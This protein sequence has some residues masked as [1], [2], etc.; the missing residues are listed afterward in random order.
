MKIRAFSVA[1]VAAFAMSATS[2]TFAGEPVLQPA[3][4]PAPRKQ[5]LLEDLAAGMRD[6]LRTVVPEIALPQ[7]DLKLPTLDSRGR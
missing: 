1:A 3:E 4:S 5:T 6:V 7:M 2:L